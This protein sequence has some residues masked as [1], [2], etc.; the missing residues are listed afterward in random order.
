MTAVALRLAGF[1]T[2]LII[3]ASLG[4]YLMTQDRRWP[5]FGWQCLKYS[6]ILSCLIVRAFIL[7]ERLVLAI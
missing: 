2:L 1:S 4:T 7:L 5:R 6:L 3:G